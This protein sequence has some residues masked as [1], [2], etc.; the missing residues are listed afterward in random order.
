MHGQMDSQVGHITKTRRSNSMGRSQLRSNANNL[1]S[2]Y[3][4]IS[5][6]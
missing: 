6:A 4:I 2:L 5:I 3:V 1:G